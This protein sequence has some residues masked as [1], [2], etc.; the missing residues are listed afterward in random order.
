MAFAP[1]VLALWGK[2]VLVKWVSID[3]GYQD[4]DRAFKKMNLKYLQ[5]ISKLTKH[6]IRFQ[7]KWE[8]HKD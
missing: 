3:S 6:V 4:T 8:S 1:I 7:R 5:Q 2:H